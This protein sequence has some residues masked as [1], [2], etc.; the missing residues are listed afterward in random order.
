MDEAPTQRLGLGLTQST[1]LQSDTRTHQRGQPVIV[2]RPVHQADRGEGLRILKAGRIADAAIGPQV[3]KSPFS[4][5]IERQSP[6]LEGDRMGMFPGKQS[7]RPRGH[8]LGHIVPPPGVVVRAL[9][10]MVLARMVFQTKA[11][12][13]G[14]LVERIGV[15]RCRGLTS[16]RAGF[17][18]RHVFHSSQRQ[19]ISELC[20]FQHPRRRHDPTTTSG[21]CL[22]DRRFDAIPLHRGGDGTVPQQQGQSSVGDVWSQHRLQNSQGQPRLM[23]Q[24]RNPSTARV[25]PRHGPRSSA[26]PSIPLKAQPDLVAKLAI[27]LGTA[28]FLDPRMLIGGHRLGGQLT[29]DPQSLLGE[30]HPL[31]RTARRQSGC[32][33]PDPTPDDEYRCGQR[34]GPTLC[35]VRIRSRKPSRT[36]PHRCQERSTIHGAQDDLKTDPARARYPANCSP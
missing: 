3:G 9:D 30:H 22:E 18:P 8:H 13:D 4:H 35:G 29:S 6:R 27:T 12:G 32:D 28:R 15:L 36:R 23:A 5:R 26:Q 31:S 11:P 10:H 33:S 2:L 16:F 21:H 14:L 25:D 7:T 24:P 19:Q 17:G 1:L 20:G 34:K